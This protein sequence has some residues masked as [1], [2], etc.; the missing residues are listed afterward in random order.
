MAS[1]AAATTTAAASVVSSTT[2]ERFIE[3]SFYG[4]HPRVAVDSGLRGSAQDTTLPQT[5][6]GLVMS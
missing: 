3:L 4:S 2:A 1:A 6:L 5:R